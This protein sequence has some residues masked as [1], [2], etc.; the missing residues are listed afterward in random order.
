MDR[1]IEKIAREVE[2]DQSG[3]TRKRKPKR[4]NFANL[5][6]Q[7]SSSKGSPKRLEVP[8]L[9]LPPKADGSM[10]R[11]VPKGEGITRA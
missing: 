8:R 11:S 10:T 6:G 7:G 1:N 4:V 5:D 2:K 9:K 3:E